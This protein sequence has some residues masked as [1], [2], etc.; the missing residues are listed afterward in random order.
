MNNQIIPKGTSELITNGTIAK[1]TLV[2]HAVTDC[3]ITNLVYIY[4]NATPNAGATN[5]C[6][7]KAGDHMFYLA[8]FQFTGTGEVIYTDN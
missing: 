8:S 4:P 5:A 7:L 6:T 1:N 3:D 2:F